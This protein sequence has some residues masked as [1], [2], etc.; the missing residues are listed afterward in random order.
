MFDS[1]RE[2]TLAIS[3]AVWEKVGAWYCD[4]RS[5]STFACV[6]I[7]KNR[8]KI[9]IK[10]GEKTLKDRR[11]ICRDI[12]PSWG[13]GLLNKQFFVSDPKEIDYAMSLIMQAYKYVTG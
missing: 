6:N 11:G 7:Q 13:Y 5:D 9:Y 2:K 4:Y 10:M 3:D 8:L 12:P 1:I